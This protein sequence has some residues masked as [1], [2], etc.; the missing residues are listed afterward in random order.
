[1][2]LTS[3]SNTISLLWRACTNPKTGLVAGSAM[4]IV[5]GISAYSV[6]IWAHQEIEKTQCNLKQRELQTQSDLKQ[7]ELQT[8]SDLKQTE[9]QVLMEKIK[10]EG[11]MKVEK[12]ATKRAQFWANIYSEAKDKEFN[13]HGGKLRLEKRESESP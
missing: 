13:D 12:E 3:L 10:V 4:V 2:S 5:S 6:S 7:T 9:L 8:Q 11:E 1:M